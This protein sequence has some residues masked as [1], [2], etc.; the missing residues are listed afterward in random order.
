[1][2]LLEEMRR[3]LQ[4]LDWCAKWWEARQTPWTGVTPELKE[5]LKSYAISQAAVQ[6]GLSAAFQAIWKT[7]L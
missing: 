6:Q 1:L 7:P 5:G 2:L 3:V 4:F